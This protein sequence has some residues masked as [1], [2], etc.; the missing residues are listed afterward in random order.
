MSVG[1]RLRHEL[2]CPDT[3]LGRRYMVLM[4][5]TI[6]W[7]IF[8]MFLTAEYPGFAPEGSTTLFVIE[9]FIFLV[10][11]VDFVLRLI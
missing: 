1:Y 9:G 4:L 10:Y 2:N 8:F 11:A 5:A 3:V 6:V 7:S